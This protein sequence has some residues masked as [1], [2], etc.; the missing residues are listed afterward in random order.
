MISLERFRKIKNMQILITKIELFAMLQKALVRT[1]HC[2]VFL[3]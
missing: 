1:T 3:V 2:V